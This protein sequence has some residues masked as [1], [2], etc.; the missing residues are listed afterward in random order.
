MNDT[1]PPEV[2]A[3]REARLKGSWH[4]HRPVWVAVIV[5]LV[6]VAGALAWFLLRA[7]A[8][9]PAGKGK[10]G[11]DPNARPLPV[12]AAP[13]RKGNIDVYIDALGTVTPRNTVVVHSRVDGQLMSVG[14]REG[15][16]VK[17]G[18]LVAQ[19]DPRPFEV[20]L[21][22]ANG[23][24]AHDQA[25]LQNARID[26]E[27]YRT[28]LKQDSIAS[29]QV[30]TQAALVRQYEG[31]VQADQ[32]AIDNAKL[33]LTYSRVTAPISGRVGLRLVDPGNIVHASDANGL[34]TITQ[35]QPITVIFPVAEDDVPRIVKRMQSGGPV[36]VDAYDRTGKTKLATGRLLTLDNQIDTT[37]G[38]VKLKAEMPND[39]GALFPNQF[40]N[41][42]MA[43]E[44]RQDAT[45]VP[46]AAIQRG[47]PGTF[48]FLVK[49]DQSVAVTPV[50]L[51][52]VEGETTEVKSGLGSGDRVVV[53]GADKLR[54]G[55]KV[56]VVDANARATGQ[57][58]PPSK[59][60]PG[61]GQ[62]PGAPGRSAKGG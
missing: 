49:P 59:G 57:T 52:A 33:Q 27:R 25:L 32:G 58:A 11:T 10:A 56:E 36:T 60:S 17:T 29:Q 42:R 44:T 14:F 13:A 51:G 23:T 50:K 40:V 28:L 9:T 37:T 26:L 22:Q 41:V 55:A 45:L 5:I 31:Q 3:L 20:Q 61:A 30:D 18:D 24:M 1:L 35:E 43:V 8:T 47:T 4:A 54:D 62:A 46:S 7:P 53:D 19:L 39:D 34:V 2:D 6:I 21:T 16:K 12:A 15:Q 38:T 48:V